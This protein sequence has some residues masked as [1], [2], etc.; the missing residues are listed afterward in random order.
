MRTFVAIKMSQF[1]FSIK[2]AQ[3]SDTIMKLNLDI[4]LKKP[5]ELY[6]AEDLLSTSSCVDGHQSDPR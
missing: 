5:G 2:R 6:V 4:I 1:L 3:V